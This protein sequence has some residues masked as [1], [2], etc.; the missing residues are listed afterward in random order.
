MTGGSNEL[1]Y[2][3]LFREWGAPDGGKLIAMLYG[4]L[5]SEVYGFSKGSRRL[6]KLAANTNGQ[7]MAYG[8]GINGCGNLSREDA[9]GSLRLTRK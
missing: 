2:G 5:K 3:R 6:Y 7:I 4:D 9:Q 1:G 8:K